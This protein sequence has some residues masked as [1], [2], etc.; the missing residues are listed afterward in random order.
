MMMQIMN[1]D[2]SRF[3]RHGVAVLLLAAA[4]SAHALVE[5]DP[6]LPNSLKTVKV[7]EPTRLSDFVRDK[8]AAIVLGKALFWDVNLGSDGK[9]SCASCH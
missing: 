3:A 8:Q 6:L 2:A 1:H 5:V 7:P 9:T 4:A